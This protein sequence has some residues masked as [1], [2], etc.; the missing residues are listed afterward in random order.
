VEA[1]RELAAGALPLSVMA[2]LERTVGRRE[3][4]VA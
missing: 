1:G 2:P 3:V 4:E